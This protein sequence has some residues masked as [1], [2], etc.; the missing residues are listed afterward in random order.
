M[1]LLF[2]EE[3]ESFTKNYDDNKDNNSS[4]YKDNSIELSIYLIINELIKR[5]KNLSNYKKILSKQNRDIF[6]LKKNSEN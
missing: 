4:L 1:S 2:D 6:T 3:N 5:T